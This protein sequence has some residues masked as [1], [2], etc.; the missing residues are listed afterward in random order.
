MFE[1]VARYP[2]EALAQHDRRYRRWISERLRSGRA[3]GAI[4][5]GPEGPCGS[6]VA[7][8]REEQPRPGIPHR[9]VPYLMSIYVVPDQRGRGVGSAVTAWLVRWARARGFQRVVLHATRFGRPVYR[10]LG[11]ERS[12]EMRLGGSSIPSAPIRRPLDS[13]PRSRP[14]R[15]RRRGRARGPAS[16]ASRRTL[17]ESP[18]FDLE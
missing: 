5:E 14:T 7:W 10:R 11:F 17:S 18:R 2:P 6:G 1:A 3:V 8:L 13:V 4:A 9:V 16:D 12:W 15:R